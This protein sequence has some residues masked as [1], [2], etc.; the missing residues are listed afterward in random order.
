MSAVA[1][2]TI[3]EVA[4]NGGGGPRGREHFPATTAQ[5]VEQAL[6]VAAEGAAIV[7]IHPY[8]D[9]TRQQKHDWQLYARAF[10]AIRSRCDVLLYPTITTAGADG[11]FS[12]Q[13]R[14]RH[15][16]ELA[17]RGLMDLGAVD[18]G[19]VS[20]A[21]HDATAESLCTVDAVYQNPPSHVMAGLQ[22]CARLGLRPGFA[23]Y[24][25]GFTRLGAHCAARV[26]GLAQPLYRFMFTQEFLWGFPPAPPFL[27]AHL[28][29]LASA[30]PG[31]HWMVAGLGTDI[32]P[33]VPH[34][35]RGGG[36]V[37]VGLEDAPSENARTNLDW[38]R[39]AT[40]AIR[41]AGGIPATPAQ[42]RALLDQPR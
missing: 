23:I 33:L 30:A 32:L 36:H 19:S 26:P 31:A 8:D 29:L 39:A 24:E 28:A 25:P 16:E 5:I 3:L 41:A 18:P 12:P 15:Y 7:H 13:G 40:A 10:E 2:P 4:L 35:V 14:Y 9:A 17:R 20:F 27:E 1:H 37:R 34:A 38:V 42:A 21:R 22:T 11:D 6:A